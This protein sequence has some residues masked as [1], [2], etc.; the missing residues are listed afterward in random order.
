MN[1]V[2]PL[3]SRLKKLDIG[4]ELVDDQLKLNA[5]EGVLTSGIISELKDKKAEIID[6]L[7]KRFQKRVV[8]KPIEPSEKKQYYHLSSAQKRLY[9]LQQV[10]VGND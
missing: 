10:E 8:F 2:L 1:D 6:F 5:P 9:I 3:I 7:Q 4:I